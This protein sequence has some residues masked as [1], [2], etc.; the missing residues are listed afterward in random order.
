MKQNSPSKTILVTGSSSGLGRAVV[1]HFSAK[2][3]NVAAT[4]R[5][6][7]KGIMLTSLDNVAVIPLDIL[8]K[9][10]VRLAV[11]Q[12]Q[13]RFNTIDVLFNCAGYGSLHVFE[14]TSDEDFRHN[15]ETNFFGHLS[16]L[17]HVL[18]I[19]RSQRSGFVV[20]VTSLAG[21]F[22]LPLQTSYCSS[23]FA[24]TGFSEALKFELEKQ[25]IDVTVFEVGGMRTEFVENMQNHLEPGIEDYRPYTEKM[26]PVIDAATKKFLK[27]AATPDE[28]AKSLYK[29]VNMKKKPFRYHPTKDGKIMRLMMRFLPSSTF[30]KLSTMGLD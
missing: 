18:P 16:V 22:G 3:W 21:L 11:H 12:A 24:M 7:S 4:M 17:R 9:E 15:F 23:K 10:S 19:M 14:G 20:N 1:E 13:T 2:G 8:S 28:V 30:H 29:L 26:G 25:N 6:T 27:T 5:D